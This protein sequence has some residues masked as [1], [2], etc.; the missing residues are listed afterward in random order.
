MDSFQNSRLLTSGRSSDLRATALRLHER[1][2][3][4]IIEVL[5]VLGVL[6]MVIG[7]ALPPLGRAREASL[8]L[9]SES[10]LK[11]I[12]IA[13]SAYLD[14]YHDAYPFGKEGK[15][16]S[17]RM[18]PAAMRE[19]FEHFEF[20]HAW[21]ALVREVAPWRDFGQVF[22]S[23]GRWKSAVLPCDYVYSHSFLARPD[24]WS[25]SATISDVH[26]LRPVTTADT[27]FPASKVIVWDGAS[28]FLRRP[29]LLSSGAIANPVPMLFVDGHVAQHGIGNAATPKTNPLNPNP[30]TKVM[31]LHNTPWGA[32][33]FDY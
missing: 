17:T 3:F 14:A 19:T 26:L 29:Q 9:K 11:Q 10:N 21:P 16:Y 18:D 24:V 8:T 32:R 20:D 23:P 2:A 30:A 13:L 28:R 33:G 31:P 6:A 4:T 1:S 5:V 7:L 12:A 15:S 27:V 22:I 25:G